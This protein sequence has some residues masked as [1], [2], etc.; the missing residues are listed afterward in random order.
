MAVGAALA[1][2]GT[3]RL[4]VLMTGDGDYLMGMTALWT[5]AN[6][7]VPL[8]TIVCNN[9]SFFNDELHQERVARDRD[10]PVQNRWIGQRIGDPDPDLAALALGL[11]LQGLGPTGSPSELDEVLARAVAAVREGATVVVD[12]HVTP[13]YSA[14]MASGMTRSHEDQQGGQP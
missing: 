3:D 2:H 7:G 5:A 9:R 8:L 10:R 14:A 6:A 11:G 1:L 4:P 13:G 12:V